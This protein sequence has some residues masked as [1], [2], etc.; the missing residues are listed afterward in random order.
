MNIL[1]FC[2]LLQRHDRTSIV[3]V[4]GAVQDQIKGDFDRCRLLGK[5]DYNTFGH[6]PSYSGLVVM[7]F[8]ADNTAPEPVSVLGANCGPLRGPLSRKRKTP[9]RP[10]KP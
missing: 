2:K 5:F 4:L 1:D 10:P 3:D 9:K 6:W 7:G 8:A